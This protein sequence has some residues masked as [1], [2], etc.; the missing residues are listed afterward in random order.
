[1]SKKE[2]LV[3][4]IFTFI[5]F[6]VWTVSNIVRTPPVSQIDPKLKK[7]LEPLN[8]NFDKT[9][10]SW[11]EKNDTIKVGIINSPVPTAAPAPTPATAIESSQSATPSATNSNL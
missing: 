11:L 1:M 2:F 6:L 8:V 4:L 9:A 5:V 10:I 7:A 3:I